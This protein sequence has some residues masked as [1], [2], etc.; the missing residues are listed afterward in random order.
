MLGAMLPPGCHY[1]RWNPEM[2]GMGQVLI[3]CTDLAVLEQL[4]EQAAAY[5]QQRIRT[6]ECL[7]AFTV[8]REP[9]VTVAACEPANDAEGLLE[10]SRAGQSAAAL[11]PAGYLQP[12]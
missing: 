1:L 10:E 8:L 9:L 3:D 12:C 2:Y 6:A 7:A 5:A 11:D 4:G